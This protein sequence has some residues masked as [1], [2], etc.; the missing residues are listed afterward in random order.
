MSQFNAP[1]ARRSGDI[2]VF[3]GLLAV[4]FLVLAAG[5]AYMALANIKH[6][7]DAGQENGGLFKLVQKGGGGGGGGRSR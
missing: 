7:A 3:T 6:S 2:D 4:A 5:V 1:I